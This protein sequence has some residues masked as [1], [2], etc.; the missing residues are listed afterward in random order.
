[1][2]LFGALTQ[3]LIFLL[4]IFFLCTQILVIVHSF[5]GSS[6]VGVDIYMLIGNKQILNIS[7]EETCREQGK[8]TTFIKRRYR[9]PQKRHGHKNLT[10]SGLSLYSSFIMSHISLMDVFNFLSLSFLIHNRQI[11]MQTAMVYV[12]CVTRFP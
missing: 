3:M 11:W 7:V 12:K 1:M 10:H 8:L 5:A 9:V 6:A 2:P 4:S